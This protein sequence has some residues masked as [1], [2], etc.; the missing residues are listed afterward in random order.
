MGEWKPR[1]YWEAHYLYMKEQR[2][3]ATSTNV[4]YL[5]WVM[6]VPSRKA[7]TLPAPPEQEN[8]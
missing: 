1:T 5:S 7:K 2:N 8:G 4:D 3:T 6:C